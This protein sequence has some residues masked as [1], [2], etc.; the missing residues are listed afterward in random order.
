[1]AEFYDAQLGSVSHT[2]FN[3]AL[4]AYLLGMVG[5]FFRM[6]YTQVASD[7]SST[8]TALGRRIGLVATA[9]TV[10]G[11]GVH[12]VS[13]V[14]RGLASDRV[15]WANM[16]EYSSMLALF[17]VVVGLV[18]VQRRLGLGHLM[19]FVLALSIVTM[20]IALM[21]H[22][23]P[24]PVVPS[25]QS[26]WIQIHVTAAMVASSI[27]MVAFAATSLYLVKDTAER[28]VAARSGA[29]YGGSTV[30]AASVTPP[31]TGQP[32]DRLDGD[33]DQARYA[34]PLAQREVL[35]P[36]LF[37][38]VP[39]GV[40]FVFVMIVWRAPIA[41]LLA[42]SV[43]A[44]IGI[45]T[46]YAVP[47]LPPAATLDTLAYRTV[48]FGFPIWTFAVIAGA[49]WAEEAWG[50]FWGWDPKET[51]SFFTWVLYAGY[52]HARAT[53]GWRG[54]RAAWIGVLAFVALMV[55]YY[56]VNLFVVGLHSY[57]GV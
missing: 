41:A 14:T 25:L 22:T 3:T 2:L 31:D 24:G 56:A 26:Y 30:G 33:E 50:R 11:A 47:H 4:V 17:A 7:G 15:P 40:V 38:V 10:T 57:A 5:Y 20:A 29:G 53:H 48:A 52:L 44:L 36:V 43:A 16:Y 19:G 21:L 27:F 55:T 12:A 9:L 23:E 51:G 6:A 42:A 13:I 54:R 46:W 39:F 32:E 28:R 49:I 8:S 37:P 45:L 35:S 1:M 34:S 18:V